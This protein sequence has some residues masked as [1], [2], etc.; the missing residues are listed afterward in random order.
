T[1]G[2]EYVVDITVL[3]AKEETML[4]LPWHIAGRGGVETKG[5]WDNDELPD[6]FVTRV[7]RFTPDTP[8]PVVLAHVQEHAQ[9]TAHLLF[10]GDLLQAEGPGLPEQRDRAPFYV[11]RVR[12][13]NARMITVIETHTNKPVIRTVSVRGDTVEVETARGTDRHRFGTTEWVIERDRES[14]ITLRGQREAT[15]PFVPLLEIDAPTPVAA[16]AFRVG[17]PPRLDGS[18]EGFD[19]SEPLELGLEDQYRRS[20]DAY[21][22]P[23]DL[24]AV[25][26]AAWDESALYVAV[27]VTKPDVVL[28]PSGAAPLKLDNEPDD[29]H[30]DGL[31][32][33]IAP[34]S[35]PAGQDGVA[36]IGYLIVP[37]DDGHTVRAS[38]T[39]DSRY[40]NATDPAQVRGAWRGTGTGYWVTAA[41]PWPPG[42]YPHAG[43][44][45]RF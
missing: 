4:E 18:L 30:S 19:V 24:S 20:E 27:E 34:A 43:G 38:P 39:S 7:Q 35:G 11:V 15:P 23:E 42:A 5:R 13:R 12:G 16:P 1:A 25:A 10:E 33:Y 26:H 8:G 40:H 2:P 28:R 22:G 29:I 45:V 32:V 37:N 9:F 41:I 36:P 3:G 17:S 6:E 21:P 14:S 44:C 31:Q